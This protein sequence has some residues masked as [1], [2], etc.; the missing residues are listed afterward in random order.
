MLARVQWLYTDDQVVGAARQRSL[1]DYRWFHKLLLRLRLLLLLLVHKEL[2]TD[3]AIL[4]R[5]RQIY[6]LL[7]HRLNILAFLHHQLL[8]YCVDRRVPH[9]WFLLRI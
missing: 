3:I 2:L 5:L 1:H 7:A 4:K 6:G 9:F 8:E